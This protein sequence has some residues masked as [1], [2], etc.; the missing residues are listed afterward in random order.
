MVVLAT[1]AAPGCRNAGYANPPD[2]FDTS[3]DTDL[4][5]ETGSTSD[6]DTGSDADTDGDTDTP[7][8]DPLDTDTADTDTGTVNPCIYDCIPPLS[9]CGNRGQNWHFEMECPPGEYCCE[10]NAKNHIAWECLICE[11]VLTAD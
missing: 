3:S 8:S 1:L 11:K 2:P 4:D 9:S 6:T 7:G 10:M 5:S